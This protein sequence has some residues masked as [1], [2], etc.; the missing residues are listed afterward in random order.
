MEK[1]KILK[2]STSGQKMK[3]FSRKANFSALVNQATSETEN[4][5]AR[6][7]YKTLLIRNVGEVNDIYTQKMWF[8][9]VRFLKTEPILYMKY[10]ESAREVVIL[11]LH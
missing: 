5:D 11:L 6:F 4:E 2:V 1:S 9:L 8:Y 3:I 7:L 10:T